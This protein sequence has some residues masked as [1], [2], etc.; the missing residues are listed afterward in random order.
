MA[1]FKF[2][3]P[4]CKQHIQCDAGLVSTQINCPACHQVI[5]V[6]PMTAN[7]GAPAEKTIQIKISTL[8]RVTLVGLC[9]LLVMAGA[10]VAVYVMGDSTRTIWKEWSVLDGNGGQCSLV[11]G[12]IHAHSV[13][14]QSILASEEVYGDVTYSATVSTTNREASLMVRMKD[15]GNGY[16]ILFA[17]VHTPCP[18][19]RSGFIAVIKKVDGNEIKIA[20]YNKRNMYSI[21]QTARL[22]VIARGPLIEVF[23][24]GAK[25]LHVSDTT[26]R[27]GHIGLRMYGDSNYPCNS[28]YSRISF[29]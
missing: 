12:K 8:R 5:T 9:A 28:T 4:H 19:N 27:S 1:E 16:I 22:K 2:A 14:G 7:A 18:W 24:N 23:V 3:C 13:D 26:F 29:H 11:N 15:A 20:N 21:G 6:P 10:A 17:P 25:I